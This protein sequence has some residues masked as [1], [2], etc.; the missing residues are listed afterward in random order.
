MSALL[1]GVDIGTSSTKGVLARD[2]GE[3]I[4]TSERPH[5]LSLPRPGW[6]EHDAETIWW[7]DFTAI[8]HELLPQ[9]DQDVAAV[10]VSGIGPCLQVAD[11]NGKPLRPA[12][13]YG[14]DTRATQEIAELSER[15]G[16]DT[17]LSRGGSA[18]TTQAIGPKLLWL[19]HYEPE[20]W[21]KTR[22]MLMASSFIV[23]RLTGEYI[24]DHHS[25]SQCDPLYDLQHNN[26][27]TAWAQEIAPGLELPR[28]LWP[29]EIAGKITAA[30]AKSTGL[31][32]GTP[33]A[34]GTIDA[35]AEAASAGVREPGDLMIMY[36]TTMFFVEVLKE[37]HPTPRLW[38]TA[39]I[40]PGT[41]TLAAGM[42][43][44]GALTGWFRNIVN[45]LPYEQLLTEAA[46]VKPGSDGLVILPYF[47]GERTPIFDPKARG[48]ISGLTLSHGRGHIYRALLEATAYGVRHI[49]ETM[50]EAGST[51]QRIVAVGGGTRGGLWTQIV[52]DITGRNQELPAQTIGASYGDAWL[53]AIAIGL[54]HEKQPWTR[55]AALIQPDPK[56]QQIYNQLYTIY[57]DLY[58]ATLKQTHQLATLQEQA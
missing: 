32:E 8:C 2:N 40:F 1:L 9:A 34:A 10:C 26:W 23:L 55:Q 48:L 30:A 27:I 45:D 5:L 25:A 18:L 6:A 35:W 21:K 36:G 13:L 14:I 16:P 15:Y 54:A 51:E 47:A 46:A 38:G 57:R 3:I 31:P 11:A 52:S 29:A 33:V 12:I 50:H 42:A 24:L 19:Q 4:A 22:Y 39:G 17:I 49:L 53:A 56:T 41:Q 43:T 37:L 44:S 28:L 7:Q 58:P 20:I